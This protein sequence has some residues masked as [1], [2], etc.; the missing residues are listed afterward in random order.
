MKRTNYC[1]SCHSVQCT[2]V[3]MQEKADGNGHKSV[4][5]V[6]KVFLFRD[7]ANVITELKLDGIGNEVQQEL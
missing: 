7:R 2:A 5:V 3:T 6:V 1:S 4:P